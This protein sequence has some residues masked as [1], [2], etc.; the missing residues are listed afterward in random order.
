[1]FSQAKFLTADQSWPWYTASGPEQEFR[2]WFAD[3]IKFRPYEY[4]LHKLYEDRVKLKILFIQG[5]AAKN[6]RRALPLT[7]DVQSSQMLYFE[8][9]LRSYALVHWSEGTI[10]T[11]PG[12]VTIAIQMHIVNPGL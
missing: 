11:N 6:L 10:R 5:P 8:A 7:S 12:L 4:S 9:R 1:M 3:E 2:R